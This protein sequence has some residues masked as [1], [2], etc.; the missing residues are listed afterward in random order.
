MIS[1]K[2]QVTVAENAGFCFGV[3]RAATQLEKSLQEREG[4]QRIV[5]LGHLIHNDIYND[6]MAARGVETIEIEGIAALVEGRPAAEVIPLLEGITC[7]MKSTS[8]P[9]Q[10]AQALKQATNA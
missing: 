4:G 10:L 9:D 7:G 2:R 1:A 6:R 8:C 3:R 5:T